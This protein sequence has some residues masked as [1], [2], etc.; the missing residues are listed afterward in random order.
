M[1]LKTFPTSQIQTLRPHILH[2][3]HISAR[4][5]TGLT[6]S[7]P[8]PPPFVIQKGGGMNPGLNPGLGILR[9]G[10]CTVGILGELPIEGTKICFLTKLV[11]FIGVCSKFVIF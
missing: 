9:C 4:Q 5:T 10:L 11:H 8:S 3:A 6:R 7:S 1:R 2:W